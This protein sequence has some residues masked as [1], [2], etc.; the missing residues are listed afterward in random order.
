VAYEAA[1]EIRRATE[2][3]RARKL[4]EADQTLSRLMQTLS[5]EPTTEA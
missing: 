4:E 3:L 1:G 5:V 2:F